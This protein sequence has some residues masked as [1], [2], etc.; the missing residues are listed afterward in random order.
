MA[1]TALACGARLQ[2]NGPTA[3]AAHLAL[4]LAARCNGARTRMMHAKSTHPDTYGRAFRA[5]D[6]PQV[7][8]SYARRCVG[9]SRAVDAPN[10]DDTGG[11]LRNVRHRDC[12]R[13]RAFE[14]ARAGGGS[15]EGRRLNTVHALD[16]HPCLRDGRSDRRGASASCAGFLPDRS[17]T[18]VRVDLRHGLRRASGVDRSIGRRAERRRW[19]DISH[20]RDRKRGSVTA[21]RGRS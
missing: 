18:A 7:S 12:C 2:R 17:R 20:Q 16:G 6:A 15:V 10:L 8:S 21:E 14:S 5:T 3:P 13:G 19:L 4:A 9:G 1:W 11:A